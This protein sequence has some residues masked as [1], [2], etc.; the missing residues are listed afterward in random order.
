MTIFKLSNHLIQDYSKY[1]QS[2]LTIQDQAIRSF[3]DEELIEKGTLWPEALLQLNPAYEK[4]GSISNLCAQ[5]KLHPLIAQ[6]FF[7]DRKGQPIELYRHQQEAIEKAVQQKPFIVTSGTGSG[8]T[9]TYFIPIFDYILHHNPEQNRVQA[10]V[11]YP[12]NALVNSQ[13]KALDAYAES[14]K[15][16]TGQEFP[17]RYKKYTGQ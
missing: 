6:L 9:L 11:V 14:Y 5:G 3:L 7:D 12:M 13:C 1:V 4:G 10:I 17:I 15:Q 16:R 8:K 2:F